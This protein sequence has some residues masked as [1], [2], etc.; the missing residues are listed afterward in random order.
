MRHIVADSDGEVVLRLVLAQ[1]VEYRPDHRGRKFFRRQA[2]AAADDFRHALERSRPDCLGE[3][4]DNVL[5]E[6]LAGRADFLGPIENGDG[7]CR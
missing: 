3:R 1:F 4:C 2:V 6:R 7:F 5:V